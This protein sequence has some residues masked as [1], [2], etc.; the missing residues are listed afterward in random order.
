MVR[1]IIGNLLVGRLLPILAASRWWPNIYNGVVHGK[2][3][4]YDFRIETLE[5][6]GYEIFGRDFLVDYIIGLVLLLLPFQLIKDYNYKK[7]GRGIAI[8]NKCLVLS[9]IIAFFCLLLFRGPMTEMKHRI[10]FMGCI[11][12]IGTTVTL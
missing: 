9:V 6:L 4:Y 5:E 2:Y 10:I 7:N 3:E 12:T 8:W 11:I 1:K